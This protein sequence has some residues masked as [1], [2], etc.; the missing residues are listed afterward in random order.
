MQLTKVCVCWFFFLVFVLVFFWGGVICFYYLTFLQKNRIRL[1]LSKESEN[2]QS[3][4]R[5]KAI[6][7]YLEATITIYFAYRI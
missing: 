4:T 3:I 2:V 7:V 6:N 5:F 1:N